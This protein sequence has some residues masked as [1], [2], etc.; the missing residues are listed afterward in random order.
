MIRI[1][2]DFLQKYL[3]KFIISKWLIK[4]IYKAKIKY[5]QKAEKNFIKSEIAKHNDLVRMEVI[6]IFLNKPE[7]CKQKG[8][9]YKVSLF[10]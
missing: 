6:S 3:N 4:R 7:L 1:L 8:F 5:S 10:I 2:N 9:N